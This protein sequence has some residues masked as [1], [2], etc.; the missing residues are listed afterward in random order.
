LSQKTKGKKE[1]KIYG[2]TEDLGASLNVMYY[3]RPDFI[4]HNSFT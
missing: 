2:N 4:N 1:K 3:L